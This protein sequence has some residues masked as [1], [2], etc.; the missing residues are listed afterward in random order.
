MIHGPNHTAKFDSVGYDE[1]NDKINQG[2][3]L[4]GKYF[5]SFW[6]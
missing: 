6:T 2:L 4:M 3:L 5:R 1:N